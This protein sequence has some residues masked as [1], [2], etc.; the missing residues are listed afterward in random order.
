MRGELDILKDILMAKMT[1]QY[2]YEGIMTDLET[3]GHAGPIKSC[4]ALAT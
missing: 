4:H 2:A 3:A 1:S